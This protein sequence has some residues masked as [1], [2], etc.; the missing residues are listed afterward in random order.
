MTAGPDEIRL[1]WSLSLRR[2]L[3]LVTWSGC[4][5]FSVVTVS[6]IASFVLT[7]L[8]PANSSRVLLETK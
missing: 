1:P 6:F 7:K 2:A 3:G 4:P 5:W 8:E